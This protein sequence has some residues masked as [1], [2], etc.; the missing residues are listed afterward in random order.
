MSVFIEC[1]EENPSNV[2]GQSSQ[3]II[4][5][6]LQSIVDSIN[7]T[8]EAKIMENDCTVPANN[9]LHELFNKTRNELDDIDTLICR[10]YQIGLDLLVSDSDSCDSEMEAGAAQIEAELFQ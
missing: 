10:N 9:P 2:N 5:P 1:L 4:P 7:S 3:Q 6:C 8:R